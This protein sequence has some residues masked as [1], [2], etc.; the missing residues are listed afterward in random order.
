MIDLIVA[1]KIT[2]SKRFDICKECP[3]FKSK[4]SRCSI[5]GCF[6]KAKIRVSGAKCPIDKWDRYVA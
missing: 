1:D 3:Y 6:M 5:C 2:A 4:F